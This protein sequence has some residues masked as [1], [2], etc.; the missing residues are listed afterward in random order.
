MSI[1]SRDFVGNVYEI[2]TSGEVLAAEIRF[3]RTRHRGYIHV[4]AASVAADFRR[5]R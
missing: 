3:T 1:N 4:F 5:Y 2:T